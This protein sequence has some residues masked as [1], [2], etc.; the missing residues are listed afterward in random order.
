MR[1]PGWA[2]LLNALV[3][4]ALAAHAQSDAVQEA[5][6]EDGPSGREIYARVL[7]NSLSS[8]K[9]EQRTIS[10]D[11]SGDRQESRF[12]ARFRDY[13][14]NGGPNADGV[15]SKSLMK[16]TF[17]QSRRDSSYLFIEKHRAENEGFNY[18]R[19]RG[20]VMRMSTREETVFGTDFTLEDLVAVRVLDDATYERRPDEEIDGFPVYVVMMSYLPES[21]PQYAR[22]LLWIDQEYFVVLKTLN[23]D[24]DGTERNVMEA[25]RSRIERHDDTWIP[26]EIVMS[27]LRDSTTSWLYTDSIEAN[28]DLSDRLFEPARLGR[29]RR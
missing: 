12:W 25:P 29:N 24:H 17:P 4:G 1:P 13:R 8:S 5:P 15:I 6:L 27:D 7:E 20:K 18:S 22:S 28:P 9:L 2:L 10:E 11:Q 23:W 14:V 21:H 3:L 26:M 19:A 16:Y